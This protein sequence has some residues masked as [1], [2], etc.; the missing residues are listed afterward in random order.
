MKDFYTTGTPQ[1]P[2]IRKLDQ[3]WYEGWSKELYDQDNSN[4]ASYSYV[5]NWYLVF[6]ELAKMKGPEN[7][8]ILSSVISSFLNKINSE[9]NVFLDFQSVWQ[10]ILHLEPIKQVCLLTF[11]TTEAWQC[12][13]KTPQ[14]TILLYNLPT[15]Q[16][17]WEKC[18]LESEIFW[19]GEFLHYFG[20]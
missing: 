4:L 3:Q 5:Y 20:S 12:Y 11:K 14:D 13:A 1:M 9:S 10:V 16:S 6:R 17:N 15:W 7:S 8:L 19:L 2:K 18:Q